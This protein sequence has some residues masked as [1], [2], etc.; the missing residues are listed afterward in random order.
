[1]WLKIK[2]EKERSFSTYLDA[3]F[4]LR[5]CI[6]SRYVMVCSIFQRSLNFV[7]RSILWAFWPLCRL[8]R[9]TRKRERKREEVFF[10]FR[11]R[12]PSKLLRRP[13]T[14]FSRHT[15]TL[16][17]STVKHFII[18]FRDLSLRP[19]LNVCIYIWVLFYIGRLW[20]PWLALLVCNLSNVIRSLEFVMFDQECL[21]FIFFEL[22]YQY[23]QPHS[24][25]IPTFQM[26]VSKVFHLIWLTTTL[27]T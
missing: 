14:A 11:G 26:S 15:H 10:L 20:Q 1:M 22:I 5:S 8:E 13:Y 27:E 7:N 17:L 2:N 4:L 18:F 9:V 21:Y 25:I 16:T 23:F 3:T 12:R 19:F 6:I 24:G